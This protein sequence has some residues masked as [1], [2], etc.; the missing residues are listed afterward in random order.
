MVTNPMDPVDEPTQTNKAVR[1]LIAGSP[2]GAVRR[3]ALYVVAGLSLTTL[4]AFAGLAGIIIGGIG[5]IAL[6][7]LAMTDQLA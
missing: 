7:L 3:I 6:L 2:N 4:I 1:N 5:I